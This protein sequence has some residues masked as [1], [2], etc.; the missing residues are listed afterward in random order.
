M[1]QLS[2]GICRAGW[3]GLAAKLALGT[4]RQGFGFGG[5]G[6]KSFGNSFDSYGEPYG[7]GDVLGVTLDYADG[8]ISYHKNGVPLGVAFTVPPPLLRQPLFPALCLKG[9]SVRLNLAGPFAAAPRGA[10]PLAAA[11]AEHASRARAADSAAADD[12][13]AQGRSPTALILE[14]S[15][16]LAEQVHE[17]VLKF[18]RYF[19][20]P[21][22]RAAL[23]VGGVDAAAQLRS[24]RSGVDVVSGTPGRVLDLAQGG[25]LSL[26]AVQFLVLDEADRLLDTGSLDAIR[27][28]HAKLPRRGRGGGRLQTLLFSATLHTAAVKALAEQLTV[29]PTS[30]DLK[31]RESV[32]ETVHHLLLTVD[33]AADASWVEPPLPVPTDGVHRGDACAPTSRARESLS[34]ATKRLKPLVLLRLAEQLQMAQCLV[35]CRTNLDCDQLEA[36]LHAVGGGRGFGGKA[37]KGLENPYSCVVLAGQRSMDQR[38]AALRAFKE[39]DVRFCICTDVAA[40]GLDIA[41]LPH[42]VNMTLPDK[43]E[44]YFHRVGRVG[45]AGTMGLAVSLVSVYEEKV[46][47]YDRRKWEGKTL[48][49]KLAEQGGCCIWYDEPALLKEV[50]RGHSARHAHAHGTRTARARHAHG[51]RICTACAHVHVHEHGMYTACAWHALHASGG[52]AARLACPD[53]RRF[54]RERRRRAGAAGQVWAGSRRRPQRRQH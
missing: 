15:R 48:S 51:M 24:L 17:E 14:P 53:A 13:D 41:Q 8:T 23:L 18:G 36:Y 7:E 25:K 35:F 6:K 30:V 40:R 21:P 37:E 42:V 54:P 26:S 32:P 4:D 29:H 43:A 31:G 1:L 3:S 33:A 12:A 9:C 45:R 47:Y 20:A 11:A 49:T 46:W 19:G 5:T 39:G 22:L 2:P 50:G 44:D 38:R 34:E 28:L 16:E 27:K 10:V 52:A